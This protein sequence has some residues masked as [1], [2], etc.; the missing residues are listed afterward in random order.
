MTAKINLIDAASEIADY[1]MKT[2]YGGR[3]DDLIEDSDGESVV[4]TQ[5]AQNEFNDIYDDIFSILTNLTND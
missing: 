3:Y 2:K 1:M 5:D 4:F